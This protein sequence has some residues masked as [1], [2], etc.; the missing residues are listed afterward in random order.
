VNTENTTEIDWT[1]AKEGKQNGTKECN[2]QEP[3]WGSREKTK[4][5]LEVNN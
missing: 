4:M 3:Y 1:N 5:N 2:E